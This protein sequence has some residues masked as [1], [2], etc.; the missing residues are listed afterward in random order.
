MRSIEAT[1]DGQAFWPKEPVTLAPNTLVRLTVEPSQASEPASSSTF[2]RTARSL[3][4]DGPPDWS[5]NL[6]AYLYGDKDHEQ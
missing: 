4:L 6:D 2:L 1:F 5:A 3:K